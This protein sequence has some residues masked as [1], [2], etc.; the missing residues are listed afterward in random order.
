MNIRASSEDYLEAAL[1][2][3]K[4]IGLV[5]SVDFARHMGYSKASISFAVSNLQ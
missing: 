4:K 2:F 3:H 5:R 1:I